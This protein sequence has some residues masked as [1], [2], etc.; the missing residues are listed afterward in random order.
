MKKHSKVLKSMISDQ[1]RKKGLRDAFLSESNDDELNE[2]FSVWSR[3]EVIELI[4]EVG[5]IEN[6]IPL[7]I[8]KA[9]RDGS[10]FDNWTSSLII[11]G[12]SIPAFLFA[13]F[14]LVLLAGV[15]ILKFFQSVV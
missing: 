7:G 4:N 10:Q 13:I 6:P 12:Y 3:P 8:R 9:V 15:L 14:L 2:I 11:I 1:K 5:E